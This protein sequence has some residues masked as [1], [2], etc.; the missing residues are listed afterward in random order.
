MGTSDILITFEGVYPEDTEHQ[1]RCVR[2]YRCD[3]ISK[4]E[5]FRLDVLLRK[6][7]ERELLEREKER[8]DS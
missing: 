1:I 3:L 2:V 6:L 5:G 8:G 7:L 4:T